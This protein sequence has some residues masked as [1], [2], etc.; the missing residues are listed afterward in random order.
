MKPLASDARKLTACAMSS[1][2]P[3]R[4]VGTG[5][6]ATVRRRR[7]GLFTALARPSSARWLAIAAPGHESD[8][9]Y[10]AAHSTYA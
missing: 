8:A 1:R 5:L 7:A 4:A 6:F 2:V 9:L 10:V 3:I